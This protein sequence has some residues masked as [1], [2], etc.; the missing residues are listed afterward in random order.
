MSS[1]AKYSFLARLLHWFFVV[2]FSYGIFKQVDDI[3]QLEDIFLLKSEMVFALVFLLFLAFRFLY[4]NKTQQTSLPSYTPRSQ[5]LAAKFVHF[6]MYISLAGIACSGLM[7]GYLFSLGTK[8]GFLIDFITGI[9][10]LLV[11]IIYWLISIHVIAAIYHRLQEDGV[12]SSMVP[13]WKEN[14]NSNNTK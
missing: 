13:F 2:L 9:H 3:N 8:Q 4:M 12:W 10:E 6:S 1:Q 14:E 11:Q 5:R 7:I